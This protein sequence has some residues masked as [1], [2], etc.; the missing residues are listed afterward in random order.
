MGTL[1]SEDPREAPFIGLIAGFLK[2]IYSILINIDYKYVVIG[3]I[4]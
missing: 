1:L 4:F 2:Y 3:E